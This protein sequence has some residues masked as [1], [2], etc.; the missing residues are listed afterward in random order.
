MQ[1][2]GALQQDADLSLEV[3]SNF[4]PELLNKHLQTSISNSLSITNFMT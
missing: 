2:A 3:F 1:L 4:Q